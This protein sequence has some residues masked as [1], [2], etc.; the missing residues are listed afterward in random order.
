MNSAA[1]GRPVRFFVI[2]MG[3]WTAIR[4]VSFAS[5]MLGS[6]DPEARLAPA[7]APKKVTFTHRPVAVPSIQ[8]AR[9]HDGTPS[10]PSSG[11][12]RT[13][14]NAARHAFLAVPAAG[15]ATPAAAY[16]I[17]DGPPS[18][19]PVPAPA[20]VPVAPPAPAGQPRHDRWSGSAWGLWRDGSTTP[21][22]VVPVGRLGGSQA[23]LRVDY[24]LT[25]TAMSRIAAYGRVSTAMNR[26]AAPEGALG[27]AWQPARSVPISLAAE[28][29]IALSKDARDANALLVVG[30]LAPT[31][32][33]PGLEAE[34]YAQ[35][36]MVGFRRKDLFIDGKVSLLSP[37]ARSPLR[38]GGSLS[39][40]AQ[41]AVERLDIGPELQIR[42]PQVASRLSIEWRERVAGRAAPMSG[43]AVALG[44]DF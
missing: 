15:I 13:T 40:G 27:I 8:P 20:A 39:G 29:R 14:P 41:P 42:L 28:R 36:G 30:G 38:L 37:V 16:A 1:S 44:T 26:P 21:A 25:P 23:G 34:A 6:P 35:A 3:G 43:L 7:G 2:L 24:D 22:S 10:P 32:V 12:T 9:I 4:I 31:P 17:P 18:A 33:V 11:A 19:A 5:D